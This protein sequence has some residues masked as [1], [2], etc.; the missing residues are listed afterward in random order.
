[1]KTNLT[2]IG[3][4]ILVLCLFLSWGFFYNNPKGATSKVSSN[5]RDTTICT[6]CGQKINFDE[7]YDWKYQNK[8][9][10]FDTYNCKLL[11]KKNPEAYINRVWPCPK[12]TL[13][14]ANQ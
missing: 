2:Y 6:V 14:T 12:P 3:G 8:E 11:F 7:N 5:V 1:M 13:P 10:Y 9:Y 4:L